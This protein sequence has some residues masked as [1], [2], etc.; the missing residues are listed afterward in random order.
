MGTRVICGDC[1]RTMCMIPG[2]VDRETISLCRECYVAAEGRG[3]KQ[4]QA[5]RP[6]AKEKKSA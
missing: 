1:G 6:P 4:L 3:R 2:R 5:V